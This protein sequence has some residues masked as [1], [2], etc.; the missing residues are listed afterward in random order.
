MEFGTQVGRRKALASPLGGQRHIS[1]GV[2]IGIRGLII[3]L[4]CRKRLNHW[5]VAPTLDNH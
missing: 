3:P 4:S 2:L 5:I 1:A